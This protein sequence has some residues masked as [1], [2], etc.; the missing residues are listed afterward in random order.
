ML[1][2]VEALCKTTQAAV[3][4]VVVLESDLTDF[5]RAIDELSSADARN[6]A[7]AH[8]SR[9]MGLGDAR[10]NGNH[11]H[12]YPINLHGEPIENLTD[13]D[14]LPL[15]PTHERMQPVRYRA[16]FPVCRRLV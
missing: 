8:A 5:P 11:H 14:H 4:G 10:Q 12:P 7:V 6:L 2:V 1:H 15:P 13:A 3:S 16:E 9:I